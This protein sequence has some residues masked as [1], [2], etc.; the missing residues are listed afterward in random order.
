MTTFF[1]VHEIFTFYLKDVLKFKCP[2]PGVKE[3]KHVPNMARN[4]NQL[5]L[6][7]CHQILWKAFS[8]SNSARTRYF[9][10]AFRSDASSSTLQL[11]LRVR[12]QTNIFA[13]AVKRPTIPRSSSIQPSL[14]IDRVNGYFQQRPHLTFYILPVTWCTNTLAFNNCTFCPHCI[15]VFCIY[16]RTNSDLRHLQHK[17]FGF[18]NRDEK[19]LLRGTNWV[20]K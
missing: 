1:F 2:T 17:L 15:Y 8:H 16:L 6:Q 11:A 3:L 13:P 7:C 5:I 19:C 12:D 14:Y 9:P 4:T 20:F 10:H 18:Y